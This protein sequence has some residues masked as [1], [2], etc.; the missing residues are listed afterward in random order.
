MPH[1]FVR[2]FHF[3]CQKVLPLVFDDSLSYYEVLA[4]MRDYLNSAIAEINAIGG[5]FEGIKNQLTQLQTHVDEYFAELD[6]NQAISDKLDDMVESGEM[7]A[8]ITPIFAAYANPLFAESVADM[9]ATNFAY[10]NYEN[11]KIYTFNQ[12]T[13]LYQTTGK[14]FGGVVSSVDKME[15]RDKYYALDSNGMLYSYDFPE[16][17]FVATG[18]TYGGYRYGVNAMRPIANVYVLTT[19][20]HVYTWNGSEY[21]DTGVVYGLNNTAFVLRRELSSADN[22]TLLVTDGWYYFKNDSLPEGLPVNMEASDGFAVVYSIPNDTDNSDNLQSE[23]AQDVQTQRTQTIRADSRNKRIVLRTNNGGSWFWNG[24]NWISD[25]ENGFPLCDNCNIVS[26]NSVCY[27]NAGTINA[28]TD[29]NGLLKTFAVNNEKAQLFFDED[30]TWFRRNNGAWIRVVKDSEQEENAFH[31]SVLYGAIHSLEQYEIETRNIVQTGLTTLDQKLNASLSA[32]TELADFTIANENNE[33]V[34]N[35]NGDEIISTIFVMK[36]DDTLTKQHTAA[37]AKA[38]GESINRIDEEL[39]EEINARNGECAQIKTS[40]ALTQESVRRI[41]AVSNENKSDID[42]IKQSLDIITSPITNENGDVITNENQNAISASLLGVKTDKTLT[43]SDVPADAMITGNKIAEIEANSINAIRQLSYVNSKQQDL[44][45][46]VDSGL[47][48][49]TVCSETGLGI[50]TQNSFVINVRSLKTPTDTSLT[51]K[52]MPADAYET[53]VQLQNKQDK[54]NMDTI[55]AVSGTGL[56]KIMT[57]KVNL[58]GDLPLSKTYVDCY[59]Q[60]AVPVSGEGST[61]IYSYY[62]SNC[63]LKV[64]GSSSLGNP[65]KNYTIKLPNNLSIYGFNHNSYNLK[66]NYIDPSQL[67]N[68]IGAELWHKA[69]DYFYPLSTGVIKTADNNHITTENDDELSTTVPTIEVQ[70]TPWFGCSLGNIC[71]VFHNGK[72]H[73][74]YTFQLAKNNYLFGMDESKANYFLSVDSWNMNGNPTP[75][76]SYSIEE[77]NSADETTIQET[78]NTLG[79]LYT[80]ENDEAFI[81]ALNQITDLRLFEI[82]MAFALATFHW[83][84]IGRNVILYSYDGTHIYPSVWDMDCIL[85]NS[86]TPAEII[87]FNPSTMLSRLRWNALF[88]RI[89]EADKDNFKTIYNSMRDNVINKYTILKVIEKLEQAVNNTLYTLDYSTWSKGKTT[90]GSPLDVLTLFNTFIGDV[91]LSVLNL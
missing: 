11:N 78:L 17:A 40:I 44:I 45:S 91:D 32:F 4:K 1:E 14:E 6:V 52:N 66:C 83:D 53:G 89:L 24:L 15:D 13:G 51:A 43:Q 86:W 87:A 88:N 85:I 22:I 59:C 82:Y 75:D 16:S 33:N 64:Q 71:P 48:D 10:A 77:L 90:I 50:T 27:C 65:E 35:E 46:V 19:D 41:S 62:E 21:V 61:Q 28:P 81:Q 69:L 67:R 5:E 20:S 55:L 58:I 2:P 3:W 80:I 36:T 68:L 76:E 49:L 30:N 57:A 56:G 72:F 63:K 60:I 37:D 47:S 42:V 8:V 54:P 18:L 26:W 39:Q 34:C 73:G 84:G 70:K 31:I 23:A 79:N 9:I 25:S 7:D 29:N 74:L 12:S 38:T